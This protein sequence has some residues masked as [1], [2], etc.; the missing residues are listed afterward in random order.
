MTRYS[1]LLELSNFTEDDLKILQC[2]N[3]LVIGA[4]GVGQ[5]V[6]TYLIAN[7]IENLTIVD[8]DNVELSNL[9][10]QI[11]L[12]EE[13]KGKPKVDVV[14]TALNR[15]NS[16][17]S[18]STINIK[19]DESN[20]GTI[21]SKKY[22]VVIDALD[23]WVGKLVIAEE[24]DKQRIPFLHI[25]VDGMRGQFCLF[26]NTTLSNI[27]DKEIISSPRDGVMGPMVGAISSLASIYLIGYLLKK[28]P[29]DELH[30]YDYETHR[31]DK[32]KIPR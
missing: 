20:V 21:I 9:N 15:K 7:G 22:D 29:S 4:G 3:V 23:N 17:V 26:E 18:I 16:D 11:L 12:T 5:H 25:G 27:V 10:R 13:D 2:K 24:C 32:M 8:F 19:V 31:F 28:V 14:K 1:R 30:Y 6:S